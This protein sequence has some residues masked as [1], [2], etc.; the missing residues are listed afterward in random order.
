MPKQ[1]CTR[2]VMDT[3]D[4][5]IIFD[6][7]GVCNH[8][9][10]YFNKVDQIVFPFGAGKFSAY[11]QEIKMAG[12]GKKYDA[13][14]GI[15][16]G[17]DSCLMAHWAKIYGLDIL[18]INLNNGYDT[19]IAQENITKIVEKTGFDLK[20]VDYID[21]EEFFDLQ[22][23]YLKASVIDIEVASDHAI[24][25]IMFRAAVEEGIS[26]VLSGMNFVTEAIMPPSWIYR[27]ADA[28]NIKDIHKKFGTIPLKTYPF[29]GL[30]KRLYYK[31]V[32]KFNKVALLNYMDYNRDEAIKLLK[33]EYGWVDYGG[34][35][36][37][38]TFTKFFQRCI[39]PVKVGVD[40]RLSHLSTLICSGQ[41]TRND[42][43]KH[44]K[45]TLYEVDELDK[46]MTFILSKLNMSR[47]EFDE[48][49]N[50]PIKKH[51][52]YKTDI[53]YRKLLTVL[54]WPKRVIIRARNRI[55]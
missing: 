35:H 18:L 19:E 32:K 39:L 55:Y 38:S 11:I 14:L 47:V 22:R 43:L 40:K 30:F 51:T 23:A 42:A 48:I 12:L 10:R 6:E 31:R 50:L 1:R 21:S 5:D 26:Y 46:D 9:T 8:C 49:M 45:E 29:L 2:C 15:S 37:E 33:K 20:R 28:R 41:I 16:G 34:K 53:I 27:K 13:I 52:D 17:V 3:S 4:P 36:L 7:N 44:L 54:L 24:G 25:S